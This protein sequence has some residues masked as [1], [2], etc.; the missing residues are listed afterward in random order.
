[1]GGGGGPRV[2]RAVGRASPRAPGAGREGV[3][4]P[5]C[6]CSLGGGRGGPPPNSP[7][8]RILS[9]AQ[10][11]ADGRPQLPLSTGHGV[12]AGWVLTRGHRILSESDEGDIVSELDE[13]GMRSER[14]IT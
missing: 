11:P 6:A 7:T 13:V 14:S 1:M 4:A 3:A 12:H 2:G 10:L 5:C 8:R 9:S